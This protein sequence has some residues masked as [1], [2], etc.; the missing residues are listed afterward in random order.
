M[1]H[2]EKYCTIDQYDFGEYFVEICRYYDEVGDIYITDLYVYQ[3]DGDEEE[4]F[5]KEY[6][7]PPDNY[8]VE[9]DLRSFLSDYETRQK[10][11]NLV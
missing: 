2:L 10:P 8:T 4:I 6:R 3:S 7:L 1:Y 9:N 11:V 5:Y